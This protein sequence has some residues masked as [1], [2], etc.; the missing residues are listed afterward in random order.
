MIKQYVRG[1]D[2]NKFKPETLEHFYNKLL[3]NSCNYKYEI[4]TNL[5]PVQKD[6]RTITE[7]DL[8]FD[9]NDCCISH[10]GYNFYIRTKQAV[11]GKRYKTFKICT[12]TSER[13]HLTKVQI[14]NCYHTYRNLS[15]LGIFND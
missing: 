6:M 15:R 9:S 5:I 8:Q 12:R 7:V 1:L 10:F 11:K 13:V 14:A 4:T 2:I 3:V